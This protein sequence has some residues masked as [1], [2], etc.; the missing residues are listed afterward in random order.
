MHPNVQDF[1]Y[2][3][4]VITAGRINALFLMLVGQFGQFRSSAW[5]E[6][7]SAFSHEQWQFMFR[8]VYTCVVFDLFF[9]AICILYT[10]VNIIIYRCIMMHLYI[11]VLLVERQHSND[12]C[13]GL[14]LVRFRQPIL[15]RGQKFEQVPSTWPCPGDPLITE[16]CISQVVAHFHLVRRT[17]CVNMYFS[18]HMNLVFQRL[19]NLVGPEARIGVLTETI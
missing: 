9:F 1:F 14:S 13:S 17:C 7:S 18:K 4:Y 19:S 10:Y 16:F 5:P 15:P 11:V 8:F 12:N 2:Q 3:Q 6:K